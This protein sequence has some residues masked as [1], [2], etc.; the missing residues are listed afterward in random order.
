MNPGKL[1]FALA[2]IFG[3]ALAGGLRAQ[4]PDT[5]PAPRPQIRFPAL[6]PASPI[7]T[8]IQHVGFTDIEIVY[9]RPSM[10]G[11]TIFGGIVPYNDLWRTGDNASTKITFST[12]VKVGGADGREIPA[13]TYALF[14]IPDEKAWTVILNKEETG[15]WGKDNYDPK[16]DVARFKVA[17]VKLVDA[18]ETFTIDVSNLQDDS[19]TINLSWARVRIPIKVEVDLVP[20]LLVKIKESMDSPIKKQPATY[21]QA[22]TFYFDHTKDPKDL[23]QALLWVKGG[24]VN[25]PP[26]EYQLLYI[27]ARILAKMG[28]GPGA[29]AAANES[30][31][32]AMAVEGPGTPYFKMNQ[33]VIASVR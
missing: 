1:P 19:A 28:D 10:R 29:I 30:S 16:R 13:G 3:L 8:N 21:L 32:L 17:P 11:H 9:S 15:G 20:D 7:C 31:R 18:V 22:A 27:E 5:T 25:H 14:T 6:P 26:I 2:F 4:A 12:P 33:E 24:L 23:A